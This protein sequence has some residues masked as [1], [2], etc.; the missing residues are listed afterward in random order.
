MKRLFVI[1]LLAF[2]VACGPLDAAAGV[3]G[4][5]APG[6]LANK[7]TL[8]EKAGIAVETMYTATVKAGALAFRSG[9]VQPSANPTVRRED[10]CSL[11]AKGEF[12]PTDTGSRL[13]SLECQLRAARDLTRSAYD[14]G[15]GESY[16]AAAREA[17]RIAKEFLKLVGG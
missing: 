4:I 10:F 6:T 9:L 14:A 15:N 2:A 17:I 13:N 16:D 1:P 5:P 3:G 11:V 7:T 8:D 12:M